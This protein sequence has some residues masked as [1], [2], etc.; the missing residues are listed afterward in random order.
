VKNA[1]RL[2]A[3]QL[4]KNGMKP[5]YAEANKALRSPSISG[6][7]AIPFSQQH[8]EFRSGAKPLPLLFYLPVGDYFS[9]TLMFGLSFA[10]ERLGTRCWPAL[11]VSL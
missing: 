8:A 1:A 2:K 11:Q 10:G 7:L 3:S 4:S 9:R 5:N 6:R